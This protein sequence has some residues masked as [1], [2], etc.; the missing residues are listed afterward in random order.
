[1]NETNAKEA[2]RLHN[3]VEEVAKQLTEAEDRWCQLQEEIGA[4]S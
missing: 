2:L 3:E 1:M 4:W